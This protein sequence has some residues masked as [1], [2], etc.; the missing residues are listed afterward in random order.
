MSYGYSYD[1]DYEYDFGELHFRVLLAFHCSYYVSFL[2]VELALV[3]NE[4]LLSIS[5]LE[6]IYTFL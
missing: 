2:F 3:S 4:F 1:Y 6:A 5:L